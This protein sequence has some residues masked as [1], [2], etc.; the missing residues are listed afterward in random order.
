[1]CSHGVCHQAANLEKGLIARLADDPPSPGIDIDPDDPAIVHE[2]H[3]EVLSAK[4][5]AEI[6]GAAHPRQDALFDLGKRH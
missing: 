5:G 1:M 3:A 6:V 2:L 4:L